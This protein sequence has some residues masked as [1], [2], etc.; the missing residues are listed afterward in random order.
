MAEPVKPVLLPIPIVSQ[1]GIKRDGTV[2][3]GD[4]HTDGR[5]VRWERGLPRKMKGY[6]RLTNL[7]PEIVYGMNV[8]ELG[9]QT[10]VHAGSASR[11]SQ[12]VVQPS[13]V[14]GAIVSRTPVTLVSD[15]N[16]VWQQDVIYDVI[17]GTASLIAHA[18][19][20]LMNVFDTSVTQ[21]FIGP[22]TSTAVLTNLT[23]GTESLV[24][25]GVVVL[26]PYLVVFGND[27]LLR[28]SV[29][30]TPADLT[31]TGSSG[32]IGARITSDKIL[33][34][35]PLRGGP[36]NS[37][38]GLFWSI[39]SLV[40]MTFEGG[41]AV[42]AFDT[43]STNI[44]VMSPSCI[45]EY[46]GI[47]YWPGVDRFYI[48]NGVLSELQ[49]NM[50]RNWFFDGINYDY[51][52]KCFAFSVPRWGEIWFCYPR[53][54]ATECTHAVILN[55]REGS[56]YDTVLPQSGR[57]AQG[58]SQIHRSPLLT[59]VDQDDVTTGYDFWR[60]EVG[61]DEV[62]GSQSLA[63]RSYYETSSYFP[64]EKGDDFTLFCERIEPDFVQVGDMNV[65]VKGQ[66]N[67]RA[68]PVTSDPRTF[69]AQDDVAGV[70]ITEQA[71]NFRE[72]RRQMRFIFESNVAGGDYQTG[73]VMA[74]VTTQRGRVRT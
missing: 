15:A 46:D 72:S 45:I 22:L 19:P 65:Y 14:I 54:E 67:A 52:G 61:T 17:S 66:P 30:N 26:H 59:G 18:S 4:F 13:G 56:W 35:L 71:V 27:G 38:A 55:V 5:W 51:R 47:Y 10:Y 24:S 68:A 40:R 21:V 23:G 3:D 7:L 43:L 42:F 29:A 53:G 69:T 62:I 32:A 41:T 60:H 34:G 8:A 57:S 31:G 16:N 2:L 1:P 36:G 20:S 49:N 28:W 48:F 63:I 64:A 6:E 37:P 50:N 11:L 9:D 73:K 44:S 39:K 12:F 58:Y 33:R 70:S 25:G 74:Y